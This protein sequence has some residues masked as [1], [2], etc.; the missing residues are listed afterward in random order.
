METVRIYRL[1]NLPPSVSKRLHAAQI[2]AA[3]VWN[4]CRD[5]HLEARRQT[6]RWPNRDDLQKATKGRFALHSQTVQVNYPA[7]KGGACSCKLG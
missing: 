3:R 1:D 6:K 5:I 2:E 7:L 4:L